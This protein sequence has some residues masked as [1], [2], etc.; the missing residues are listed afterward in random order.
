L[1]EALALVRERM[2]FA[3]ACGRICL[4]RCEQECNRNQVDEP[5]AIMHLKRFLADWDYQHKPALP[6]PVEKTRDER[7]AVIG[8]GPAG[9]TCAH[10]LA[11]AGYPVTLF[12]AGSRLGGILHTCIP[13]FRYTRHK[14]GNHQAVK[15]PELSGNESPTDVPIAR[16]N[17][18]LH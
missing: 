14:N 18:G 2:P 3:A 16:Q 11:K 17:N 9:L 4:H 6:A 5:I 12:E 10:D 1:V 7:I 8:G 13:V 15:N